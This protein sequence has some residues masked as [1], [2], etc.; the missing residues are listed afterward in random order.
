[1]RKVCLEKGCLI[2]ELSRF[3]WRRDHLPPRRSICPRTVPVSSCSN[4]RV[5]LLCICTWIHMCTSYYLQDRSSSN[6]SLLCIVGLCTLHVCTAEQL[7]CDKDP[8][9]ILIR[10]CHLRTFFLT[11]VEEWLG[12]KQFELVEITLAVTIFRVALISPSL[13]LILQISEFLDRVTPWNRQS[14]PC[15]FSL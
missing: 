15:Y 7:C 1:M 6:I 5:V 12:R 14:R 4:L 3:D 2:E 8:L 13:W 10:G 9:C 11:A